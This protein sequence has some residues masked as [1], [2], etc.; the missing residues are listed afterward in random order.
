MYGCISSSLFN[1]N[2]EIL[3]QIT[4]QDESTNAIERRWETLKN[5]NCSIIAIKE[6]GGSIT[7]DN[8]SFDKEYIEE[9]ELKMYTSE[10]LSKRWRVT[11]IKTF[12]NK[13]IYKEIDRIS[14]PSTIFEVF[15]SH[16]IIDMFGNI[17]YYENH[18]KRASVQAND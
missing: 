1:M 12:S 8:K 15:S 11:N 6:T 5:I 14:Q 4:S 10:Q 17:D 2:A 18:L 13:N 16:P 7:S 9:L 3:Y